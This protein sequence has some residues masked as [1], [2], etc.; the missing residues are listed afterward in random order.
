MPRLFRNVA[1][2]SELCLES[3]GRATTS[4]QSQCRNDSFAKRNS[5]KF[6]TL[7]GMHGRHDREDVHQRA[8]RNWDVIS[9]TAAVGAE[10]FARARH[11]RSVR[12][13]LLLLVV[14]IELIAA[15]LAGAV[16]IIQARTSTRPE[17]AASMELAQRLVS[18]A[19]SPHAAGGAGGEISR[20][21]APRSSTR[22]LRA[23]KVIR[24]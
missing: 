20:S 16:T 19:V 10:A 11:G 2:D 9:S 17:I 7:P 24:L 21:T 22:S 6:D 12:A 1:I 15:L 8:D 23:S 13:Q 18:E 4:V 5:F 14:A 3:L